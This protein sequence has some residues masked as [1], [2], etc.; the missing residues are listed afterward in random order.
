[1]YKKK[2]RWECEGKTGSKDS[3]LVNFAVGKQ[4]I[5]F[6]DTEILS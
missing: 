4:F 5:L 6:L 1:M 3:V 2:I